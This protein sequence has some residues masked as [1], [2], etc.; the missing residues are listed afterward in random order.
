MS[1][2]ELRDQDLLEQAQAH[3]A[4]HPQLVLPTGELVYLRDPAQ[5][6]H[7]LDQVREAKRQLDELRVLLEALLRLESQ[8]VGSKT[9]HLEGGL[10]AVVSGGSRTVYDPEQLAE[11]LEQAGLPADRLAQAVRPVVEWKVDQRVLKQLEASNPVYAE[12]IRCA[13]RVEPAAVRVSVKRERR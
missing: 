4:E 2:L 12:A 6:A 3:A 5:V 1:E 8:R 7:G 9:L 11:A 13:R 10:A